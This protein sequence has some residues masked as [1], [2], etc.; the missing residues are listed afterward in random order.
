MDLREVGWDGVDWIDLAQD[1][2]VA[3]AHPD[4]PAPLPCGGRRRYRMCPIQRCVSASLLPARYRNG[5]RGST[6]ANTP[7]AN[8]LDLEQEVP[9]VSTPAS[10][11]GGPVLVRRPMS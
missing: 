9:T 8:C 7:N 1:R 4:L 2:D 6:H 5:R 3:S 11:W 10:Y